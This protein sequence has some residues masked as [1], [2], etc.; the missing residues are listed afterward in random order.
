MAS[1]SNNQVVPIA[2][3]LI[4]SA[5]DIYRIVTAN[6]PEGGAVVNI[7]VERL[8]TLQHDGQRLSRFSREQ[9]SLFRDRERE[10]KMELESLT[11]EKARYEQEKSRKQVN[12]RSL[13]SQK[14]KLLQERNN[15]QSTLNTARS[16]LSSAESALRNAQDELR[17]RESDRS[18][19]K[20]VAS[21]FGALLG[22]PFGPAGMAA[23]ASLGFAGST[24]ITELRGRVDD[25]RRNV[26]GC[27][28][29]V[30][31][32]EANCRSADSSFQS[33]QPQIVSCQRSINECEAS[34]QHCT[35]DSNRKQKEIGS[36]RQTLEFIS[37]A[38]RLW[39]IFEN[40][41]QNAIEQTSQFEEIL[42]MAQSTQSYDFIGSNGAHSTANSFLEAWNDLFAEH[43][44][45]PVFSI[46][47]TSIH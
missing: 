3:A 47:Q 42:Q 40:L 4:E 37:E 35:A 6:P 26:D 34:I 2:R 14:S 5:Q 27:Q 38:I 17:R 23:G 33:M 19:T 12:L 36:V 44:V 8:Q 20:A 7:P 31:N 39:N 16:T 18:D 21:F 25:A 43:N 30:S 11:R 29:E 9:E 24:V 22:A 10:Q 1:Q 32:A 13:E 15:H 41:S 28:R 45:P 46:T